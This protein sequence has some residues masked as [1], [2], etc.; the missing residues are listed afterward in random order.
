MILTVAAWHKAAAPMQTAISADRLIL[1]VRKREG[2]N[3]QH[4]LNLP[5]GTVSV[6]SQYTRTESLRTAVK[7]GFEEL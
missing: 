2:G 5:W 4:C 1:L 6:A 3:S 7:P